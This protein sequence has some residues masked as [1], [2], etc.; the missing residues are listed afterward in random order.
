[1][2]ASTDA[3]AT[4]NSLFGYRAVNGDE[5]ETYENVPE[6]SHIILRAE[7]RRSWLF[8]Q[9][10]DSNDSSD[11]I[12]FLERGDADPGTAPFASPQVLKSFLRN[13][14]QDRRIAIGKRELLAVVE[15]QGAESMADYQDVVVLII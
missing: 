10:A 9:T 15:L 12:L 2:S 7:G 11:R 14:L 4:W 8:R 3:G 13:K 1:L 6:G 5:S